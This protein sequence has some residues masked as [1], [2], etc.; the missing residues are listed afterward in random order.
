MT[1]L[2]R[3]L[4]AVALV[5]AVGAA[6]AQALQ[7]WPKDSP[8]SP[9]PARAVS[10]P[11]YQIKTLANGLQVLVVLHHEEPS[12]SFRLVVRAGAMQ[13]PADK[14]GVASVVASLLD[15][16]T[17][18]KSSE[19]IA[20]LIESAGGIIDAG[21]GNELS[22]ITGAVLKD[23]TDLALGLAADMA[24]H[25][26]FAPEEIDRQRRQALSSLQVSYDD[27]SYVADAVFYR[28]AFGQHPYGR[29]GDGTPE[30]IARITREDLVAFHKAWFTPNNSLLALVGDLTADE[31]MAAAERA[32][33]SWPRR[34][35]PTTT[36]ADPPPPARRLVVVDRP[37]SAQT[38]I[39]IGHLAVPR[40]SPD[41]LPLDLAIR[42]LGGEGA[43]RLFGVLRTERGLTYGASA[44]MH[45]YKN[46]GVFVAQ[47]NTR[48]PTTGEALRLMVDEFSRLRDERVDGRELRGA[49]EYL[50]G[51]FPLSI[52][53][54]GAIALQVLN[55]LF[56][57]MSLKDLETFRDRVDHVSVAD[58]Q[59]VSKQYLKPEALAVVLVGDASAFTDQLKALGFTDVERIPIAQLDLGSPTLR[60]G[61]PAGTDE[62][63]DDPPQA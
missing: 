13:E 12:V 22:S 53:T 37:G 32:F 18:S 21:S 16:G 35:V 63:R 59:R 28:L 51:N 50:S 14:P 45:T 31:A 41:Y 55:Q 49:Q 62:P 10:F 30:S 38:E 61:P 47:T 23:Q 29:P 43:N 46:G 27:P 58:I 3:R 11:P 60:R 5:V 44:D 36:P 40:T 8:P 54:P 7:Q 9:L 17:T 39:R 52:E 19:A 4:A 1:P 6:G 33:G 24:E 48:T 34:E 26:A 2:A 25:P 57:G 56:Y 42:I 20:D 15:Q